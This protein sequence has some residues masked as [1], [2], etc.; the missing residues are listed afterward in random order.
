MRE[1]A[2]G[3]QPD[4]DEAMLRGEIAALEAERVDGDEARLDFWR[5]G[6]LALLPL[7]VR[8]G[9]G[10]LVAMTIAVVIGDIIA[11]VTLQAWWLAMLCLAFVIAIQVY[12]SRCLDRWVAAHEARIDARIR[13]LLAAAGD[14]AR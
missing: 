3:P 14:P 8:L 13:A 11:A 4:L 2:S 1:E 10:P 9:Q 5:W 12:E 7:L 6:G